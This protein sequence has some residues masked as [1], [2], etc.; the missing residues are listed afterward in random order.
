MEL[1][2]LWKEYTPKESFTDS[3]EQCQIPSLD[4]N[5]FFSLALPFYMYFS[6][7]A[8]IYFLQFPACLSILL[9]CFFSYCET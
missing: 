7:A 2:I 4:C 5:Y 6:L 3:K 9:F 1:D 8:D